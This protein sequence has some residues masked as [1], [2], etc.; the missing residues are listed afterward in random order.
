MPITQDQMLEQVAESRAQ[1]EAKKALAQMSV[2]RRNA[3]AE[4]WIAKQ[5]AIRNETIELERMWVPEHWQSYE[6]RN[7]CFMLARLYRRYLMQA[8]M[9]WNFGLDFPRVRAK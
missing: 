2:G 9:Y 6:A 8:G 7:G 4:E 3:L 1:T 5:C